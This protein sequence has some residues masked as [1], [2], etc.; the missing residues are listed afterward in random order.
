MKGT[1]MSLNNDQYNLILREYDNR[2]LEVRHKL[3]ERT[4]I[5]EKH[6]PALKS[7]NV[8]MASV[9]V[10]YAK[11]SLGKGNVDFEE[12]RLLNHSLSL[13]KEKLLE[14]HGFPRDYLKPQY[15]CPL[16]QDTGFIDSRR[17]RCFQQ[18]IVDLL[19]SQSFLQQR[20]KEENFSTFCYDFY[21]DVFDAEK[22]EKM[23]PYQNIVN[24]VSICRSF[25]NSFPN[26]HENM[27][28]YGKTGVGKTFLSNCIAKEL[29]ERGNTI[30]YLSAPQLFDIIE[31]YKFSK[32]GTETYDG[33]E[34]K[35]QYI[36]DCDLLIID[37]LGTEFNNSFISSQLYYCMNERF[38]RQKST[39]ISTNLSL[40]ELG[41]SYS[42]RIVSR[43]F[44]DYILIKIY[45]NDI[46]I[47]KAGS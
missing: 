2:Q 8:R 16:C 45:G 36:F 6:I 12:L 32:S 44:T 4:K 10:Q 34:S 17:C 19:Y 26:A 20:L 33:M 23:T 38:L 39:L 18:A 43:F 25:I 13:E 1:I 24:A 15:H 21:E 14:L 7:I 31:K 46:R 27:M 5:A 11:H 37:D 40:E 22:S 42:E 28:L 47:K 41:Q 3:E 9:S 29:L 35:I 30:I